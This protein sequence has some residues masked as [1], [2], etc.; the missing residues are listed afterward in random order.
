MRA[1]DFG[2]AGIGHHAIGAELVA[3]FLHGEEG[4][5]ANLAPGRQG[6]ELGFGRHVGIDGAL[7]LDSIGNQRG[8]AMIGLRANHHR[9]G[10]GAGHDLLAFGLGNA[11]GNRDHRRGA[12]FA[13]PVLHDAAD[14]GIDLLRRLFADVAGVE[15]DKVRLLALGRRRDALLG[16]QFGHPLAV[17]DVHLAAEALDPVGPGGRGRAHRAPIGQMGADLKRKLR[18]AMARADD[19]IEPARLRCRAVPLRAPR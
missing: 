7:A 14:V 2:A 18:A 13:A 19:R 4:R 17:I 5:R 16:K 1:R 3:A 10:R 12:V 8:Q 15:H 9:D 6:I 11:P